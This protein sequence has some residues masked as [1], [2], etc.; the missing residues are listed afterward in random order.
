M[1]MIFSYDFIGDALSQGCA[2]GVVANILRKTYFFI[3]ELPIALLG[4]LIVN[5]YL[6][7]FWVNLDDTQVEERM[8]IG[9]KK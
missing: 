8:D 6:Q 7:R 4:Q 5:E 9:S 1:T 3:M 2:T